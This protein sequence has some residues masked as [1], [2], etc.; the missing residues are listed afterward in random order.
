MGSANH[1]PMCIKLTF[2]PLALVCVR[3]AVI[4]HLSAQRSRKKPIK[5]LLKFEEAKSGRQLGTWKKLAIENQQAGA[6][7]HNVHEESLTHC[8]PLNHARS[9]AAPERIDRKVCPVA[10][11]LIS[12]GCRYRSVPVSGCQARL[13]PRCSPRSVRLPSAGAANSRRPGL[14]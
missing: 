11:P 3:Y 2:G 4:G 8:N 14:C 6:F 1:Q 9:R 10:C 5:N 7:P 13:Q 12:R